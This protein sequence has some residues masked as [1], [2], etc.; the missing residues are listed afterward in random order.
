M[1]SGVLARDIADAL[2]A[3]L[4]RLLYIQRY[5]YGG[6]PQASTT[7]HPIRVLAVDLLERISQAAGQEYE[8]CEFYIIL[9]VNALMQ[10]SA[11]Y[12]VTKGI[13]R[14]LVDRADAAG[15]RLPEAVLAV[16]RGVG[17]IS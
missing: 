5:R 15:V 2:L 13:L 1:T 9:C 8:E 10:M 12:P 11:C 4:R 3:Q 7:M 16:L 14:D 6:P 17:E